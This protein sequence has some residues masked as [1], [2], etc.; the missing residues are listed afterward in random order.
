MKIRFTRRKWSLLLI[1]WMT[2]G[3]LALGLSRELLFPDVYFPKG[4][5]EVRK[6]AVQGALRSGK[7]KYLGGLTSYWE[8]EWSTTLVYEGDSESLGSLLAALNGIDGVKVRVTYFRDLSKEAGSG[9]KPG[10]WWVMYS[11]TTPD[12]LTVRINGAAES[13]RKQGPEIRL[14]KARAGD[15]R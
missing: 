6:E 2:S 11:H 12:T 4:Y 8:P 9:L 7:L 3:G 5:Q 13:W 14:P 15:D 10:S 1:A